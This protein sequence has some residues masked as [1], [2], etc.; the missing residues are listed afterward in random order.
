MAVHRTLLRLAGLSLAVAAFGE[1]SGV[2]RRG[3]ARL[4]DYPFAEAPD[5]QPGLGTQPTLRAVERLWRRPEG[6][7]L[8]VLLRWWS[9]L[10]SV[11]LHLARHRRADE[12][13]GLVVLA[14]SR[15]GVARALAQDRAIPEVLARAT[16]DPFSE[17]LSADEALVLVRVLG[18]A[19]R[20]A[21]E[22]VLAE[23][24]FEA[25]R[26]RSTFALLDAHTH[27]LGRLEEPGTLAVLCSQLDLALARLRAALADLDALAPPV[28]GGAVR[29]PSAE[30]LRIAQAF[31]L[32]D[33]EVG[34]TWTLWVAD[35]AAAR[36][37][38]LQ[39]SHLAAF[40]RFAAVPLE[41]R[42]RGIAA[43]EDATAE[44][45][46]AAAERLEGLLLGGSLPRGG[47]EEQRLEALGRTALLGDPLHA[48]LNRL[49]GLLTEA[50]RGRF[51]ALP[52]LDRSLHLEGIRFYDDWTVTGRSRTREQQDAL[53][54]V[55]TPPD[56]P[57]GGGGPGAS[58]GR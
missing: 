39:G 58:G 51:F 42:A 8:D 41:A 54:R 14:R 56:P 28:R 37:V 29:A 3:T 38:L 53:S 36:D 23:A 57:A 16:T 30:A 34:R 55:L 26:A 33:R 2:P 45:R 46:R 15:A 25:A 35:A 19:R 22:V 52:W 11:D 4:A 32:G 48:E 49:V 31:V 50:S 20:S 5:G 13:L 43:A 6:A 9:H 17:G 44:L 7:D 24:R 18:D 47:R 1:A 40:D 12:A 10:R 27:G 21:R